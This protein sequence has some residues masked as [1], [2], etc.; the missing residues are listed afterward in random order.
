[1]QPDPVGNAFDQATGRRSQGV[2]L[3]AVDEFVGQDAG[4][5]GWGT[6]GARPDAGN[7][8]EADVNLLVVVVEVRAG[9]VGDA[10]HVAQDDGDRAGRRHMGG[11][12]GDMG[13]FSVEQALD[14]GDGGGQDGGSVDGLEEDVGAF[15]DDIADFE[16][17]FGLGEGGFGLGRL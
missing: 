5:L 12:I 2:P 8:A 1:M 3:V 6:G 15:V 4:D 14:M 7:V 11:R 16:A 13:L 9:G 17:Q 10:A